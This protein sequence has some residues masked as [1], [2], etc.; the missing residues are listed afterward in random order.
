MAQKVRQT[1]NKKPFLPEWTKDQIKDA[2]AGQ[3]V[4]IADHL[5]LAEYPHRKRTSGGWQYGRKAGERSWIVTDTGPYRGFAKDWSDKN[6]D[7]A[8]LIM[9]RIGCGFIEALE[10]LADFCGIAID[11]T[12]LSDDERI[13]RE[14]AWREQ[15]A[16]RET[17]RQARE[18]AARIVEQA[19]HDA[20]ALVATD[21]CARLPPCN[22]PHPYATRKGISLSSAPLFSKEEVKAKLRDGRTGII[23]GGVRAVP[24]GSLV[25]PLQDEAGTIL[26]IQTIQSDGTKLFLS[27]GRKKGLFHVIPG[28][29]PGY[30]VEG[31]ATGCTVAE[32]TGR[33]VFVALDAGNLPHVA[34]ALGC[35]V[36]GVAADNDASGT[37]ERYAKETGLHCLMPPTVGHDW[38]DHAAEHG[39]NHVAFC[40]AELIPEP[41]K[42]R[43]S[44]ED[45]RRDLE[46]H[47]T[48]WLARD[49]VTSFDPNGDG[50]SSPPALLLPVGTGIGKTVAALEHALK[51][52]AER[53]DAG[54]IVV[55]VPMHTLAED[56]RLKLE[57]LSPSSTVRV[58]QGRGRPGMCANQDA[59]KDYFDAGASTGEFCRTHCPMK[60]GCPYL[61]QTLGGAPTV[62]I[63]THDLLKETPP[64]GLGF[65]CLLIV[66]EQFWKKAVTGTD[67]AGLSV[68]ALRVS[69]RYDLTHKGFQAQA[70]ADRATRFR[71]VLDAAATRGGGEP[72]AVTVE[73]LANRSFTPETIA[74]AISET[75]EVFNWLLGRAPP[76]RKVKRWKDDRAALSRLLGCLR[77]VERA[78]KSGA[79]TV[80]RLTAWQSHDATKFRR[81]GTRKIHN[82]WSAPWLF[83]DATAN[84][85]A[86]RAIIPQIEA[87]PSIEAKAPNA[88]HVWRQTKGMGSRR[89]KE[90]PGDKAEDMARVA[91]M[92]WCQ[93]GGGD[94]LIVCNLATHE[95]MNAQ[96]ANF[97]PPGWSVEH[98]KNTTG[99]DDWK[100]VRFVEI[101]GRPLL[102]L[103]SLEMEAIAL[104]SS[105]LPMTGEGIRVVKIGDDESRQYD[106]IERTRALP[107]GKVIPVPHYAHPDPVADA[108]LRE[109]VEGELIQCAG[110]ARAVNRTAANPVTITI[111]GDTYPEGLPLDDIED[112]GPADP[113]AKMLFAGRGKLPVLLAAHDAATVYPQLWGT[114]NAAKLEFSRA[115]SHRVSKPLIK[116]TKGFDTLWNCGGAS[117]GLGGL[118]NGSCPPYLVPARY[119]KAGARQKWKTALVPAG[120]VEAFPAWIAEKMGCAVRVEWPEGSPPEPP[121][122]AEMMATFT[123]TLSK[124]WGDVQTLAKSIDAP[125]APDMLPQM[126]R[127]MFGHANAPP[128]SVESD[129]DFYF[130]VIL[131][132]LFDGIDAKGEGKDLREVVQRLPASYRGLIKKRAPWLGEQGET[133]IGWLSEKHEHNVPAWLSAASA[134]VSAGSGVC[135]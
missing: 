17:E 16:R 37:G 74:D 4:A 39:L 11:E 28:V 134:S 54:P 87:T 15:E 133:G 47:L 26:N 121:A 131:S 112:N 106:R 85:T 33:A 1:R 8:G 70:V 57:H 88:C 110:R 116:L 53:P 42:P 82:G 93:S 102:P 5:L 35:R 113:V 52:K 12:R 55:S 135:S 115:A 27:G 132:V 18:D 63:V 36:A 10:W 83:L 91:W 49:A 81:T 66:D 90:A 80:W 50:Q 96:G 122:P 69:S 56:I 101:F 119:Q 98:F 73:E 21:L 22:T 20:T 105:P 109:N 51:W 72:C 125:V 13:E 7:A 103:S 30:L 45:A 100:H 84:V 127:L 107:D 64:A 3:I 29:E 94:G 25:I 9:D 67:H 58:W 48:V 79:G 40:L 97:L 86:L 111:H 24:A 62:W 32:A 46:N 59:I 6:H 14:Q 76:P 104:T 61:K 77:E 129:E 31:F 130:S 118:W 120:M 43:Q 75:E 117:N 44:V 65:P 38:N 114:A 92:R 68:G 78:F 34:N 95:Y 71:D 128:E 123:Q 124:F 89:Q 60:E 99:R 126:V 19:A 41:P 108:I 2:A 23:R